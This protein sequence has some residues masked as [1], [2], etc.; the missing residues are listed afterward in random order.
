VRP[1]KSFKEAKISINKRKMDVVA[2][3]QS[4]SKIIAHVIVIETDVILY[5]PVLDVKT[6]NLS[7]NELNTL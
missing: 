5:A 2:Q 4:V 6:Y 1:Q 3:N 7:L